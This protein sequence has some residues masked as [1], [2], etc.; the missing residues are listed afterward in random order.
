M[1]PGSN[2]PVRTEIKSPALIVRSHVPEFLAVQIGHDNMACN[3]ERRRMPPLDPSQLRKIRIGHEPPVTVG[4]AC[5]EF[6]NLLVGI[7]VHRSECYINGCRLISFRLDTAF[8]PKR[9][10]FFFNQKKVAQGR[11]GQSSGTKRFL[12]IFDRRTGDAV[13]PL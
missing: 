7:C 13:I 6:S 4:C 2:L 5:G 10:P 3:F 8:I 11:V 9:V 12:Y 1:A